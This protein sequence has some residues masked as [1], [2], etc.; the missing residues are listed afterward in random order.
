[1][2]ERRIDP[3]AEAFAGAADRYDRARPAY[4]PEPLDWAWETLGLSG[5]ATV[6]DLAAGTGKLAV[7]LAGRAGRLVAVEPLAPMREVLERQV[8]EV[9]VLDGT[10]EHMPL[11]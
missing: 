1:M 3:L 6:V 2:T 10:A 8:P 7:Q 9:E 4:R 11:P 5:S